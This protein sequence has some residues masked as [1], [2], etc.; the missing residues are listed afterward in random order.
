MSF[1]GYLRSKQFTS[2]NIRNT[3]EHINVVLRIL[4]TFQDNQSVRE[5]T[6]PTGVRTLF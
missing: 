1:L 4:N 6:C 2:K 3:V 5:C